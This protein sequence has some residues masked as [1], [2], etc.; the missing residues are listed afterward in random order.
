MLT[1][2]SVLR[3]AALGRPPVFSSDG[4]VV[5]SVN[6]EVAENSPT[7]TYVGA[8]LLAATDPDGGRPTYELSGVK[9]ADRDDSAFFELVPRDDGDQNTDDDGNSLQLRVAAPIGEE[10]EN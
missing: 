8:P 4:V 3:G 5:A 6:V 2:N 10:V 1:D 9:D 7:G